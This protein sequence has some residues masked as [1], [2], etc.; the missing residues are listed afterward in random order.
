[1]GWNR[2]AKKALYSSARIAPGS[3]GLDLNTNERTPP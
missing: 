2:T 3:P 1:M